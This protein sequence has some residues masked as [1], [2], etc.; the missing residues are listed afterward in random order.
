MMLVMRRD[1]KHPAIPKLLDAV[2]RG[3]GKPH[4]R[5]M[6]NSLLRS[7]RSVSVKTPAGLYIG[8]AEAYDVDLVRL[9]RVTDR[10]V[11]GLFFKEFGTPLPCTHGV[12]SFAESGLTEIASDMRLTVE[13]TVKALMSKS[14]RVIGNGVFEYWFQ[15]TSDDPAT[16]A[17][18]MRFYN[19]ESF[20][21]LTAPNSAKTPSL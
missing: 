13:Q 1:V 11:K 12:Q 18:I 5:G 7:M 8:R 6:L 17:W 9:G 2:N 3:L 20:L 21:C 10:I 16:T 14:P 19:V 15:A 4:K